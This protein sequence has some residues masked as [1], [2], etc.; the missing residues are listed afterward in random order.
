MAYPSK[1]PP[2]NAAERI[3]ELAQ[4]GYSIVGIARNLGVSD[5][6]F[7][8]WL[9]EYPKLKIAMDEGREIEHNALYNALFVQATQ[10][11][12]S[13]AAMFLLKTRHGYREGDQKDLANTISIEFKLPGAIPADKYRVIEHEQTGIKQLPNAGNAKP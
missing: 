9:K 8:K 4:A 3:L 11:N 1:K 5:K 12:N 6:T 10:K 2:R 13:A 7:S